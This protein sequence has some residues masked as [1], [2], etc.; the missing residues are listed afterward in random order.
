[1]SW[2]CFWEWATKQSSPVGSNLNSILKFLFWL[3]LV[4]DCG[5]AMSSSHL[6][7][8]HGV[9][10]SKWNQARTTISKFYEVMEI[11]IRI[12]RRSNVI[13][14]VWGIFLQWV[15]NSLKHRPFSLTYSDLLYHKKQGKL[16]APT[17]PTIAIPPLSMSFVKGLYYNWFCAQ[18]PRL[19][20]LLQLFPCFLTEE[21]N[22]S[23]L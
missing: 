18:V 20:A 3:P 21:E 22:Q 9:Y 4:V 8:D 16:V 12:R 17:I 23:L 10:Y 19:R 14:P 2:A 7:I 13:T 1:M 5:P 15:S 6:L 11:R